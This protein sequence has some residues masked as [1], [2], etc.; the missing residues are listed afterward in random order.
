LGINRLSIGVQILDDEALKN[1]NR[2]QKQEDVFNLMKIAPDYFENISVDLILGLPGIT[3]HIWQNTLEKVVSWSVKHISVY[4]LTVY[5]K[6]PL[7][8]RIKQDKIIL[9]DDDELVSLYEKTVLFLKKYGFEQYEISNFAKSDFQSVHNIS[10]WDRKPY[11]G[12]GLSASSFDGVSRFENEKNLSLYLKCFDK[13]NSQSSFYAAERLSKQQIALETLMLGLRQQK[14]VDLHHVLYLLKDFQRNNFLEKVDILVSEGLMKRM[15]GRLQLT[16]KGM[17]L[18]NEV[19]L[20]LL[21][22]K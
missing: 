21:E 19:I 11:K 4:F 16:L 17:F 5:E 9:L 20:N 13:M 2:F 10:Y 6:T 1:L 7:F 18:E 14:G 12:F 22:G 3:K 8:F 15:G